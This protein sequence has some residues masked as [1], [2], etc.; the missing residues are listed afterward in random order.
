M[1]VSRQDAVKA[2][3]SGSTSS[4]ALEI[5]CS[6]SAG[7]EDSDIDLVA[8]RDVSSF[9]PVANIPWSALLDVFSA[10]ALLA[11]VG[12]HASNQDAESS[13]L[14]QDVDCISLALAVAKAKGTSEYQ[15][16]I[17]ALP[18]SFPGLQWCVAQ[19]RWLSLQLR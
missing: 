18:I 3:I 15:Q 11:Q 17:D 14:K 1:Q 12:L 8:A 19:L 13:L 4:H 7:A 9:E 10:Q 2:L 5:S 16:Y 6:A